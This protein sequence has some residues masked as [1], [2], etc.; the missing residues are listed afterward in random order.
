MTSSGQETHA[1]QHPGLPPAVEAALWRLPADPGERSTTNAAG[2]PFSS[3][4]WG[5][6]NDRPLILIHGVTASAR[7]WW[8]IGPALAASGR[9]VVAVDLPGHGL[10]GNWIGHH[11]I[12][13]NAADVAAWIRAAALDVPDVQ[14]VGHSWGAVTAAALPVAGIRP[15]TLVLLDPPAVPLSLIARM[16]SDRSEVPDADFPTARERLSAA[17]P[18]WSAEDLDAKAEAVMQL[19]VDAARAVVTQNGDWDAGLADL[20]DRRQPA[21][22]SASSGVTRRLAPSS[23]MPLWRRSPRSSGRITSRP[24]EAPRT[25]RSART[26]PKPRP[27][28]LAALR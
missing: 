8:R 16:A 23:P 26:R 11:R 20:A 22:P 13:D 15:A 10:T 2:I 28:I 7:I 6:P 25:R 9:R 14:V 4:A 5:D 24:S 3:L 27:T 18:S 1:A 12:R 21:S 19:D 17:N